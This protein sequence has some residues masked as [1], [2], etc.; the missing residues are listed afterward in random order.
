MDKQ[1]TGMRQIVRSL[2]AHRAAVAAVHAAAFIKDPV[3]RYMYP[4]AATY[5][6]HAADLLDA[7]GGDAVDQGTAFHTED[8]TGSALWFA[9]G[10]HGDDE[11]IGRL[12]E[13]TIAPERKEATY[14]LFAAMES[15]HPEERHWFLPLIAV[16]PAYQGMGLGGALLA[17]MTR[18]LDLDGMPAYLDCSNVL[19][20]P[21]YE[22]HG[23]EI[24]AEIRIDGLPPVWPMLRRPR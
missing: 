3:V 24:V 22:R 21:L 9:P 10:R 6:R 2:G 11:R 5:L 15:N 17:D 8:L 1:L 13:D 14:Q 12:I 16:D 23:F 7:Y 4:E 18:R 19:N 20:I